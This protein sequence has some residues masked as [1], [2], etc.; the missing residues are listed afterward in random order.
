M[1]MRPS[2]GIIAARRSLANLQTVDEQMRRQCDITYLPY[3]TTMELTN[4]YLEHA[5]R[6]DGF[7]FSGVFPRDYLIENVC[8]I[9]KPYRCFQPADR[10]FYRVIA[11]LYARHPDM[12]FRRV[13]FDMASPSGRQELIRVFQD[14][15]GDMQPYIDEVG[16]GES[17]A[18]LHDAVLER[19]RAHWKRGE[20]ALIVTGLSNLA[21]Q[22]EREG[23][24]HVLLQPAPATILECL[25]L[26]LNDVQAARMERARTAC[27]T[28][29]IANQEATQQE[30]EQLE[31]A[32]EQFNA[33][34]NMAFVLRRNEHM[35]DA[36][37]SGAVA[38]EVTQGYTVCLLSSWLQETLPFPV[39][40]GWGMGFDIVTA[41]QNAMRAVQQCRHDGNGSAY[42]VNESGEMI[43]P[44]C[45]DRTISYR[46]RPDARTSHL[47]RSLGISS[48]NLEKLIS[49]QEKKVGTEISAS[50]LV[51][52]LD[53]TPRSATRI[54]SKLASHGAAVPVG[55]IHLN[56]RG[57]PAAV[58]RLELDRLLP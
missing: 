48:V 47:A 5:S 2:I 18:S 27:C 56:G 46:I 25:S 30:Y 58:Y 45:G 3:S 8:S 49:L 10:E 23:I 42:M 57:R 51:F 6:F 28:V 22:L 55:S 16:R 54:L 24:P 38:K 26:L 29:Q 12:D 32:L 19:Y 40:T 31:K 15:F 4:L 50:D 33:R 36:V 11:R 1:R 43:G 20:V 41:H 37:T 35:Y 34:Q 21:Q 13:L 39:H 14:V 9:S 53:I 44:L 17:S 52:Y 7:L